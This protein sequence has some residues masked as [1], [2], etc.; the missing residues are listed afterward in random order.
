MKIAK[1]TG[2]SKTYQQIYPQIVEN[3]FTKSTYMVLCRRDM[4]Q[5]CGLYVEKGVETEW[6]NEKSP[7][8]IEN[9]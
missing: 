1:R 5:N 4:E 2:F 8:F 6:K 9:P 7:I 3:L